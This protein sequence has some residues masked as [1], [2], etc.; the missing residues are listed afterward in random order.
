MRRLLG[1]LRSGDDRR[2]GPQPALADLP[3]LVEERAGRGLP[4]DAVR[5]TA[6]PAGARRASG[7][8]RTGSCRRR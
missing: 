4:V 8:R 2:S 6:G 3:R 7:W 5:S 1:V